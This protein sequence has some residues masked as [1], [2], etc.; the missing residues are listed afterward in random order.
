[1]E[2]MSVKS[3]ASATVALTLA[4]GLLPTAA[5]AL[6]ADCNDNPGSALGDAL[7]IAGPGEVIDV[8]GICT[9]DVEIRTDDLTIQGA[10]GSAGVTGQIYVIG[11]RRVA[12]ENLNVQGDGTPGEHGIA[13]VDNAAVAIRNVTVQGVQGATEHGITLAGG[14]SAFLEEVTVRNAN[15]GVV[16]LGSSHIEVFNGLLV[17]QVVF[18]GVDLARGSS[19]VLDQVTIRKSGSSGV[20]AQGSSLVEVLNNSLIE[21]NVAGITLD[22]NSS[23]IIS[24]STI[25][26]N[27]ETGISLQSGASAVIADNSIEGHLEGVSIGIGGDGILSGNTISS[28]PDDDSAALGVIWG[29]TARLRGGNTLTSNGWAAY[30][31]QGSTLLQHGGHDTLT[32]RIQVTID[33]NA[34]FRNVKIVGPIEVS[35]HSVVRLRD[36]S[37]NPGNV[38]V[39][40]NTSV[41]RDSGLNFLKGAGEQRVRVVGNITCADGESSLG[42]SSST[43]NITG[44]V[45]CTGY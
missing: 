14:A 28:S 30:S 42:A 18:N 37:G 4:V 31:Q 1:M 39:T 15:T 5:E 12:I 19:A 13:V 16:A 11:A 7:A 3:Y 26:N 34:E 44:K 24:G 21:D 29:G 22:L 9:Q 32:G 41:S 23:G 6:T 8:N 36:R 43:A 35:D 40:G 33:S 25:R 45:T 38:S 27:G 2:I 17:E 10:V 20:F